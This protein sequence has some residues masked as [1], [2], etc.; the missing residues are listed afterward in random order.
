MVRQVI[1]R[2][3]RALGVAKDLREVVARQV[4]VRQRDRPVRR[5]PAHGADQPPFDVRDPDGDPG[6]RVLDGGTPAGRLRITH[7]FYDRRPALLT[8][9]DFEIVDMDGPAGSTKAKETKR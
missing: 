1:A 8:T 9:D 7:A 4:G 5:A 6:W 3:P 2:G